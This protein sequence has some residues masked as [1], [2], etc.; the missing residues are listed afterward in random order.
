MGEKRREK[1]EGKKETRK[2]GD[3][4]DLFFPPITT[5]LPDENSGA[6]PSFFLRISPNHHLET[7]HWPSLS[8]FLG[9]LAYIAKNRTVGSGDSTAV[10]CLIL[11]AITSIF[12]T[13]RLP[14]SPGTRPKQP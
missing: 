7:F 14:L 11:K 13:I 6:L 12:T 4:G 10:I 3:S 1:H 2:A 5:R 8:I 9:V